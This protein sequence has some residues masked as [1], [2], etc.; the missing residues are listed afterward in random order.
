MFVFLFCMFCFLFCVFCV[1]VLF[2]VLFLLMYIV[3]SF[4]SVHKFTDHC[5]Q[6]ETQLQLMNIISYHTKSNHT[7][8]QTATSSTRWY[9]TRRQSKRTATLF[10]QDAELTKC[11]YL[12]P[13]PPCYVALLSVSLR[14]QLRRSEIWVEKVKLALEQAMKTQ[15][16]S[17]GS[18]TLSLTSALNGGGWLTPRPGRVTPG[19]E[20][21][22]PLHR[23]LC[24]PQDRCGRVG[25]ISPLPGF[26]TPIVQPAASHYT[27]W[28]IP[29]HNR[30]RVWSICTLMTG[31][32]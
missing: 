17:R 18:S 5:H 1:S 10:T 28:A 25:I 30:I 11:R 32:S 6:L 20:T 23:S 2:C 22:Y 26:D 15:T 24:E 14:C 19:K 31:N 21:R 9:C 16:G 4:L 27:E 12:K 8:H 29:T 7:S 13:R 3:V